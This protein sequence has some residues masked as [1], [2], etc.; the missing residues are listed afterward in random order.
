M[1]LTWSYDIS[2]VHEQI[3]STCSWCH[4]KYR[5]SPLTVKDVTTIESRTSNVLM[6]SPTSTT[7]LQNALPVAMPGLRV[8]NS[9][10]EFRSLGSDLPELLPSNVKVSATFHTTL[11]VVTAR[12]HLQKLEFGPVAVFLKSPSLAAETLPQLSYHPSW[13]T[14]S[15]RDCEI[16]Q[17]H[18]DCHTLVRQRSE[19][20]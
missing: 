18:I 13:W 1:C 9:R 5:L 3:H 19:M 6:S 16:T 17:L 11:F 12:E 14:A 20:R 7:V 10:K 8:S 4:E 2:G 15:H